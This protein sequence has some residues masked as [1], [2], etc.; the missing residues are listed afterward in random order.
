VNFSPRKGVLERFADRL[1]AAIST[2]VSGQLQ[3]LQL[4]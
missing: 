2:A 1:G 3:G 4:R